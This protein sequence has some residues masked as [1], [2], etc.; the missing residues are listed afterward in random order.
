MSSTANGDKQSPIPAD[1]L[2]MFGEP[3]LMAGED[4]DAYSDILERFAEFVK[5]TDPAEWFWIKDVAD[6][7]WEIV[8]LRRMKIL[9]IEVNRERMHA[10]Q[11]TLAM[12]K[13][14]LSA[15]AQ[16]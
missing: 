15:D 4:R 1:I 9:F 8:K 5:P 6:H 7:T 11:E 13:E 16:E 12:L 3:P 10:G 14:D 2:L